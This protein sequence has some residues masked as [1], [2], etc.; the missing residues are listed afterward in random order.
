MRV[1][2]AICELNRQGA[3]SGLDGRRVAI[4][5]VVEAPKRFNSAVQDA[6]EA[7]LAS[8]KPACIRLRFH[9]AE[10][11]DT[12]H[13]RQLLS[14]IKKRGTHGVVLKLPDHAWI[15]SQA[16]DFSA[17][18]I[19][20]VSLATDL[21]MNRLTY[22]GMNNARAGR[23]AAHLV[24][25]SDARKGSHIMVVLSS[26]DFEAERDRAKAF[27]AA[28][29]DWKII[30]IQGGRGLSYATHKQVLD[31]LTALDD[32]S[33]VYSIGGANAAILD[34]FQMAQRPRPLMVGHDLDADNLTLLENQKLDFVIYH[35]L[36]QDARSA[37]QHILK[38]HRLLPQD[39]E[40][41][42]TTIHIATPFNL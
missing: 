18:G 31:S 8:L 23:T 28:L 16:A 38:S 9:Q 27:A 29:P 15:A 19:T 20:V 22:I 5:V 17:A 30:E 10:S 14:Q 25:C 33:V 11:F 40:I 37:C 12:V 13:L 34:A 32:V 35:D 36:R 7:E 26:D 39:L 24:R 42:D 21:P 2:A 41:P 1:R 4:D 3:T 6:F